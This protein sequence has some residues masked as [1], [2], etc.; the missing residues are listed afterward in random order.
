LPLG[1]NKK[2]EPELRRAAC[3]P[4]DQA[5]TPAR[6]VRGDAADPVFNKL[7]DCSLTGGSPAISE[8]SLARVTGPLGNSY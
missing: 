2:N 6:T 3:Y 5:N 1:K 7:F 4:S 8:V